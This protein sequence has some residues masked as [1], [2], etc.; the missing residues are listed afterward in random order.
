MA[1]RQRKGCDAAVRFGNKVCIL[2]K[3]NK[4][5]LE[6]LQAAL[7]KGWPVTSV[8]FKGIPRRVVAMFDHLEQLIDDE[9]FRDAASCVWGGFEGDLEVD[10]LTIKR[11]A[12]MKPSKISPRS[13]TARG[14]RTG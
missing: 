13:Q 12:I 1:V 5:R 11:F 2:I 10:G 8:D 7:A 3:D 9:I 4:K 14:S 6:V